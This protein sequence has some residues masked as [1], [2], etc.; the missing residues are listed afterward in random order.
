MGCFWYFHNPIL[1]ISEKESKM[2]RKS[3]SVPNISCGHCVMNIKRELQELEGVVKVE[4]DPN[5]KQILVE[6][7]MPATEEKIRALLREI[8]YPAA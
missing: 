5:L 3:F 4:G 7:N 1:T 6:W 2:E 8:N